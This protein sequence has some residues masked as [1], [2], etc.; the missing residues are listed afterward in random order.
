MS[1]LFVKILILLE[2]WSKI[3]VKWVLNY[4]K[5]LAFNNNEINRWIN[6]SKKDIKNYEI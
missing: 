1:Y 5:L 2:K 6:K 4:S 3:K